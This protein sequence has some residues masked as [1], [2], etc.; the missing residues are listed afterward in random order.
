MIGAAVGAAHRR[1]Q[2]QARARNRSSFVNLAG[3]P[4]G[5]GGRQPPTRATLSAPGTGPNNIVERERNRSSRIF[6]SYSPAAQRSPS[7]VLASENTFIPFSGGSAARGT[8]SSSNRSPQSSGSSQVI[9]TSPIESSGEYSRNT[10]YG[11]RGPTNPPQ[12]ISTAEA[13]SLPRIRSDSVHRFDNS[14][15]PSPSATPN[16]SSRSSPRARSSHRIS[17]SGVSPSST[18]PSPRPRRIRVGFPETSHM[19]GSSSYPFSSFVDPENE[20]DDGMG[21]LYGNDT[22]SSREDDPSELYEATSD[23][24]DRANYVHRNGN[25]EN[26]TDEENEVSGLAQALQ[27]SRLPEYDYDDE[28]DAVENGDN[29]N[30]KDVEQEYNEYWK[31]KDRHGNSL[32]PRKAW[33]PSRVIWL[34]SCLVRRGGL[35]LFELDEI[36]VETFESHTNFMSSNSQ[37]GKTPRD[38]MC[39]V[40]LEPFSKENPVIT[41]SCEH[42][43]H[44]GCL[45]TWLRRSKNCPTC[46][47]VI[48]PPAINAWREKQE[49]KFAAAETKTGTETETEVEMEAK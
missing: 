33:P 38:P 35:S 22:D 44:L 45:R 13:S 30:D 25:F 23:N 12:S 15:A 28:E 32:S 10:S 14:V 43:Y 37:R 11:G 42:V 24:G 48:D 39:I 9:S 7:G 29:W 2:A 27:N 46:R 16:T 40:C 26:D 34:N 21:D 1:R 41:L 47:G 20:W 6:Q 19:S 31:M 4:S 18:S 17:A 5:R 8:L 36:E 49:K 3:T